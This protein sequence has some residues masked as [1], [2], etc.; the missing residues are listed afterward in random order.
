MRRT[1]VASLL[2]LAT[3]SVFAQSPPPSPADAPPA[4]TTAPAANPA[5]SLSIR[6]VQGTPGE[7]PIGAIPVVVELYHRG[8]VLDTIK[9]ETDEH[10]VVILEQIS[11]G[12]PVQPL[13]KVNFGGL[14]YQIGGGPLDATHPHQDLE[15]VC[16]A[17]TE[18]PPAWKVPM[19]HMMVVPE[20]GGLR[21]TE[22]MVVQNP[23]Q[24]TWIGALG[25]GPKRVTTLFPLPESAKDVQLGRG[26]HKWCCS[27]LDRGKLVN[28]LP[29][30]PETTEMMFSYLLPPK[31]GMATLDITA[32]A[33]VDNLMVVVPA[34]I[35]TGGLE[36]LNYGGEQ[37]MDNG[38]KG[39]MKVR[40]YNAAGLTPGQKVS[41]TFGGLATVAPA[42]PTAPSGSGLAKLVAAVGGGIILLAAAV[43]LLRR[44]SGEDAASGSA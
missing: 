41:L 10:G 27:T 13:V 31:D 12:M 16:F 32:P 6:V 4:G 5:G 29:L 8:M 2:L 40:V 37:S 14:D 39:E 9:T 28:H 3:G 30:M 22:I 38:Q 43:I 25:M 35:E 33:A 17:P 34:S 44:P 20:P 11:L 7:P 21:V 19:V 24:R 26:F 18:T 1:A 15:V 36:G 42:D 23:E